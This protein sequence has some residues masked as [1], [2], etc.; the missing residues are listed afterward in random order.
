VTNPKILDLFSCF[1]RE[2]EILDRCTAKTLKSYRDAWGAYKRYQGCTCDITEDRL[3]HF[4]ITA[5]QSGIKPG[6]VNSYARGLNSFITW[7][8]DNEHIPKRLKVPLQPQGKRV[9]QTY[10]PEDIR[11]ITSHKPTSNTEKRLMAILFL[12]VDVGARIDEA[13]SLKRTAIDWDSLMVVLQGKG[14]KERRVPMGLECRRHL[15]RWANTHNHELVFS[16]RDGSKLR[17]DNLRRD[18][19]GLLD[20]LGIPKTEGCFHAFRIYF[21]KSYLRNGG[22][23]LYLQRVFGHSTLEMTKRY[24]EADDEDLQIAHRSLSPLDQ[25]KKSKK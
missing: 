24:V 5:T 6:A 19:L 14:N 17:Y 11:K 13:L 23:P 25:I 2:K 10:T 18:F 3:K 22:N 20:K 12:L 1:I 15:F 16:T 8:F 4:V 21:G 9:L 7:L